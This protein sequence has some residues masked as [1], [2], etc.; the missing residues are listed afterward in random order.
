[1]F[2]LVYDFHS[3]AGISTHCCS[4]RK[5][6]ENVFD[7]MARSMH[8]A[9]SASFSLLLCGA[10]LNPNEEKLFTGSSC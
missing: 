4:R 6:D 2:L 7:S 1:V 3:P 10:A 5:S 9:E 8:S